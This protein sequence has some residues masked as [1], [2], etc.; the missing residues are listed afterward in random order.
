VDWESL[1]D[2]KKFRSFEQIPQ[3]E[4]R[5]FTD[6]I[7]QVSLILRLV[8]F[9]S[10]ILRYRY[11]CRLNEAE[12]NY[13]QALSAHDASEKERREKY[14]RERSEF[15]T[16]QKEHN[17]KVEQARTAYEKLDPNGIKNYFELV[18]ERSE[19]PDSITISPAVVFDSFSKIVAI[20][21]E[22]PNP[23]SLVQVN[24]YK[25]SPSKGITEKPLKKAEIESNYNSL[26]AQIALRTIHEICE[27]DYQRSVDIVVFNGWVQGVDK[28]SGE[29][30]LNCIISLQVGRT[31]F[32]QIKLERVDPAECVRHLRGVSAGS[33][34]NLAPVRPILQLNTA[35]ERFI[36]AMNVLDELEEKTNLAVMAWQ[37][38]EVLVRDLIRKE[39]A[40][41]GCNVEVIRA[42]RDAGVDAIAFDTDPI[43]GGKFIIQAKRYHNL[44]PVGA[45]R[46]LYGTVVNEGAVKGILIT[47]SHYGKDAIAWQL[48]PPYSV[49]IMHL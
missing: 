30:F 10:M 15:L 16:H 3:P 22:L 17:Y 4:L 1:K 21:M 18:L 44:V 36:T 11:R 49:I 7:R 48:E 27:A 9:L 41:D 34:I 19:Y 14:D 31:E 25:Y 8:P 23:T 26:V 43:R 2:H 13:Q 5:D 35:D 38:F 32:E 37:D 47:T 39:F 28:K 24:E 45:V 12:I 29:D 20:E 42:S 6:L 46:G 33:L 40:H